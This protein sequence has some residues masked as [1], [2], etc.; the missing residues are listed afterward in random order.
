[1]RILEDS[2]FRKS[3]KRLRDSQKSDLHQAI[4]LIMENPDV[5]QMKSGDLEGVRVYK[6]R[7]TRQPVL[8]AYSYD[9]VSDT[10]TLWAVGPHENFYRDL[11]KKN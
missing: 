4:R 10:L 11:K 5:G 9:E 2:P 1:M 3:V 6:F 8:L 7:M